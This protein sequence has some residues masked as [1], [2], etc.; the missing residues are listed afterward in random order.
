VAVP[1]PDGDY[2]CFEAPPGPGGG[3]PKVDGE[4]IKPGDVLVYVATDDIDATLAKAEAL[5]GKT[6]VPKTEIPGMGW[7]ALFSDP[8][9]NCVGLFTRREGQA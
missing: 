9:G 5:G 2:V 6:L 3:F 4:L 7:W 8:T 1:A